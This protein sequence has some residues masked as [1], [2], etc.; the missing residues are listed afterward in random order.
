MN[1]ISTLK[2]LTLVSLIGPSYFLILRI[3]DIVK[4][5]NILG[6]NGN[7]SCAISVERYCSLSKYIF[8]SD[9]AMITYINIVISFFF[10][11]LLTSYIFFLINLYK[12]G[13]GKL[14]W[15]LI[16]ITSLIV[17]ASPFIINFIELYS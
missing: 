16:I 2:K 10:L 11:L 8:K 17:I 4:A 1:K 15:I 3:R 13:A 5:L 6:P 14:F 12:K 9:D 7:Y